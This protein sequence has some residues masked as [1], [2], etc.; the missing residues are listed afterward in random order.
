MSDEIVERRELQFLDVGRAYKEDPPVLA[1]RFV[2]KE[3]ISSRS[4]VRDALNIPLC[5]PHDRDARAVDEMRTTGTAEPF[6]KEYFRKD[7]SRVPVP[8]GGATL[9]ERGDAVMIFAVDLSERK[10]AEANWPRRTVSRPWANSRPPS[11]TKSTNRSL[12]C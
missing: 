8:V 9:D 2:G 12:H 6:E 7:G 5:S 1:Q 3:Q 10:R 4:L 11:P